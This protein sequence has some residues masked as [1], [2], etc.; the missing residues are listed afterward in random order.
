LSHDCHCATHTCNTF[1]SSL[2]VVATNPRSKLGARGE[3]LAAEHL[4]RRGLEIVQRNYR[5]RWGELDIIAADARTLVFCEVKSRLSNADRG[6]TTAGGMSGEVRAL[7]SV[8]QR[9]RAQVRRLAGHWLSQT[10]ARP[11][12]PNVRFDVIGVILD[13][14]G[15]LVELEHLEGAF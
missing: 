11:H 3:Q 1:W 10:T 2:V 9:K 12:A 5:T 6:T 8:R 7:E 4:E 14:H 13:R 15:E